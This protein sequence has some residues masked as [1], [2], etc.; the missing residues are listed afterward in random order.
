MSVF[1]TID[2]IYDFE[3]GSRTCDVAE[4]DHLLDRFR[5]LEAERFGLE[6]DEAKNT[7]RTAQ[8]HAHRDD[9]VEGVDELKRVR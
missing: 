4:S 8:D 1:D 2:T 5:R 3:A 9:A 7:L 6:L